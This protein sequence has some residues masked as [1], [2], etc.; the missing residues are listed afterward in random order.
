M[1]AEHPGRT[2]LVAIDGFGGAG[3]TTLAAHLADR[4]E[5]AD[6]VH[7]DDFARP[8]VAEWEW[9]RFRAQ[10][11]LPLLAGEPACYQVWD[12]TADAA[13]DWN[14]LAPGRVLIVEGVSCTR[15]EVGAPWDVAVWVD[16]PRQERLR[17][18]VERDGPALL[19]RWLEDWMPSEQRW[20]ARDR[21]WDRVDLIVSGEVDDLGESRLS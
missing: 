13:G 15:D 6:V 2:V 19:P 7:V 10:V 12:W 21:P 14:D 5:G 4:V 16:T 18:T 1:R 11:L 20:A 17:R 8:S 9:D 3:K